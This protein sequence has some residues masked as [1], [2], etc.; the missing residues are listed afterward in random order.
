MMRVAANK[1]LMFNS[2][3]A[4]LAVVVTIFSTGNLAMIAILCVGLFNS[5]MFPTI[6]SLAINRL[7]VLTSQGSGMLC[8]AIVGGALIPLAQGALADQIGIQMAFVIPALC[9]IYILYYGF[10]GYKVKD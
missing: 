6:F 8:V 2:L 7:G 10:S 9:Y 3:A 5:I 4:C 1:V